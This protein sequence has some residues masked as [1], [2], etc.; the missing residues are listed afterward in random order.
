M[1]FIVFI[2]MLRARSLI[3]SDLRKDIK[4]SR[5]EAAGISYTKRDL[6]I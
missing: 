5:L 3:V 6:K 1:N 4:G 2:L